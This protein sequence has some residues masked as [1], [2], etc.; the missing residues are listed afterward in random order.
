M[1]SQFTFQVNI[2][3]G[4]DKYA[5][6]NVRELAK[7]HLHIPSRLLVVD[8]CKP[9]KTKLVDPVKRFPEP[10]FSKRVENMCLLAEQL[11]NEGL[12]TDV[13]FIRPGD[14]LLKEL[15][16]KYL[17]NIV[18][19]THG[20]GG[21]AQMSY[22]AAIELVNTRY[23]LHYDGD[24]FFYQECGYEWWQEAAAIMD[25]DEHY[26]FAA[27]RFAAPTPLAGDMPGLYKSKM[28]TVK[29]GYWEHKWFS[30]RIFLTDK[31]KL[32]KELPLVKGKLMMELLLRK[33]P[34]RAFPLDPEIIIFKRLCLAK[35]YRRII[36]QSKKAWSMHP[37]DKSG[38]FI[39][40]VP[41]MWD[42][43]KQNK[44]PEGQG[45]WEDIVT[46]AWENYL[47]K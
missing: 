24:M 14:K 25:K 30:T 11:K 34:F 29:E 32:G 8:C 33:L 45:G 18:H 36:L 5:A 46:E 9:Q 31:E 23:V 20:A 21:T 28:I 17:N 16:K 42:A 19:T 44:Y 39:N 40:M 6:I 1:N 7:Y 3:P 13:Y 10:A 15:A 4:D 26:L 22:W 2:S 41:G 12:F 47:K 38:P 27:P 35:H 37:L 43:V